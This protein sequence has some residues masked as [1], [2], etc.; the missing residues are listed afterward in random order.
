MVAAWAEKLTAWLATVEIGRGFSRREV[1]DAGPLENSETIDVPPDLAR[2]IERLAVMALAVAAF[3]LN[4]NVNVLGALLPFLA[5]ELE[6]AGSDKA[7]L[8]AC[9]ALGTAV[10]SLAVGFFSQRFGRKSTLIG[11]LLLFTV[12]SGLHLLASTLPILLVLRTVTGVAAGL[13]YAAASAL[14]AEVAPYARRG[15][16]MGWFTAGMFLAVPIGMPLSVWFASIGSWQLIFAVQAGFGVVAILCALR[17]VPRLA[18]APIRA[19]WRDVLG[20]GQVR[21]GLFATMLHVGSFFTAVQLATTW[22]DDTGHVA[23]EDQIWLWIGLGL[24]SVVGSA[25]LGRLSDRLGKRLFVLG[26][27]VVL[28]L[29]FG[30]LAREPGPQVLLAVAAVLALAAAARTGPLQALISGLV[31][32]HQLPALMGLRSAVMQLGVFLF[33][34]ASG[35]IAT[36]L[37]FSGVLW[38]AAGCQALS[39]AAIRFGVHKS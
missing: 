28:V 25:S 6:L 35:P 1:H 23:K 9:S 24:L 20:N 39:Y 34:S 29:C 8:I 19:R 16:A 22:L 38:F 37:G 30:L 26:C 7:T 12:A 15:A 18:V 32:G 5:E 27:S 3:A 4:L 31:D 21:A 10:G 2:G 11:G 13:S 36:E 14:A 17:A 33:A